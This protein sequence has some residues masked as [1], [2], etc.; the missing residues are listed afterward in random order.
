MADRPNWHFPDM[1]KAIATVGIWIGVGIGCLASPIHAAEI[2]AAAGTAT[3]L[4]WLFG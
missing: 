3:V 4:M 2:A 1:G